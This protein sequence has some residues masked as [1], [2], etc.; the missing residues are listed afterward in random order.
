MKD[1]VKNDFRRRP[2]R[3]FRPELD[4]MLS[5]QRIPIYSQQETP[6]SATSIPVNQQPIQDSSRNLASSESRENILPLQDHSYDRQSTTITDEDLPPTSIDLDSLYSL[7]I[8]NTTPD[9]PSKPRRFGGRKRRSNPLRPP[10]KRRGLIVF[11][12]LMIIMIVAA[13]VGYMWYKKSLTPVDANN[14]SQ[15]LVTITSGATPGAIADTLK[16]KGLIRNTWAFEIYTRTK[17]V[18]DQ[19]QAGTCRLSPSQSMPDIVNKLAQGCHETRM[20]TFLPGGT[21]VDSKYKPQAQDATNALKR[22][23]YSDAEIKAALAKTYTS[24]L[25]ADK[26]VGTSL[27]GYIYGDT[28]RIPIVEGPEAALQAAFGHMYQHIRDNGLVEKFK[29][30]KLNLYQAITL[31]SVVQREMGCGNGSEACHQIQRQ[32]AQVFYKRLRENKPLGSDVTFIYGADLLGVQPTVNV[33]SPYNTRTKVG[34]PPGPIASPG[35]G[36]LKAVADP[37]PGQYEFFVAGDDGNVYFAKTNT[38]H[39]ANIKKYCKKLCAEF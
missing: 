36:A 23:G 28:Y 15:S 38:E 12:V 24:P 29:A 10:R 3:G 11:V 26:P 37:A 2:G 1:S 33:D 19:L 8:D 17:G 32:I 30:Q 31:A 6:Q 16:Q 4:D 9:T 22:A 39:Q 21:V 25:F 18:R 5:S 20:V 35:I 14:T 34:L 7:D 27:E 13:V